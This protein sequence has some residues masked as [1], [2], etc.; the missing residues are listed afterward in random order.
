MRQQPSCANV[1]QSRPA[2]PPPPPRAGRGP[3][4]CG[5]TQTVLVVLVSSALIGLVLEAALISYLHSSFFGP[6]PSPSSSKLSAEKNASLQASKHHNSLSK[7]FAQP[8]DKNPSVKTS[9]RPNHLSKTPTHLIDNKASL[10]TSNKPVAH[11]IGGADGVPGKGVVGWSLISNHILRGVAYKDGSL[12]IRREGL[13][14]VYSKVRFSQ[15]G[16]GG[17]FHHTVMLRSPRH[18]AGVVLLQSRKSSWEGENSADT[19]LAG[20]FHLYQ[21]D[22][23]FV[24]VSDTSQIVQVIANENVFGAFMI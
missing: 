24:K 20:V 1:S 8:T 3:R 9:K 23:V 19:F 13:Y 15:R 6:A 16:R 7:T 21:H 14:Y 18:S 2:A 22:A 10:Q 11:L 17:A 5:S 4:R 12:V